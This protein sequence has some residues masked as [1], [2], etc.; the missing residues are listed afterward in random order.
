M[1]EVEEQ[2]CP[3]LLPKPLTTKA[4]C[5]VTLFIVGRDDSTEDTSVKSK[6]SSRP[7]QLVLYTENFF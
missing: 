2:L 7:V 1:E 4:A 3:D 6:E 5:Y